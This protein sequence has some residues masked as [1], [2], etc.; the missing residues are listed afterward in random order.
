MVILRI[1]LAIIVIA[2]LAGLAAFVMELFTKSS[3]KAYGPYERFVKR[4]LDAFL[5]MGALIV[6]SPVLLV[7]ALLVRVKL[8]SPVLFKQDRPGRDEKVFRLNKFR[9]MTDARDETG[10]MLPDDVR[11]TKFGRV[12]RSTSLDEL[13]ELINIIKGDMAVIGPRPLLTEYLPYYTDKERHR[14]D[15]RPGLTGWAQV[16]GRN[17]INSW[18]ERFNYDLEY[19][20]HVSFAMDLKILFL[21]VYKVFKRSDIQVGSE[22]KAGRLDVARNGNNNKEV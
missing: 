4:P 3:H 16:N 8:G 22:I 12:L 5:S 2:A 1:I 14:H 9:S 11:L 10:E 21:T 13:P 7:T 17:A 15:V 6:L 20:N 19:V 18:V